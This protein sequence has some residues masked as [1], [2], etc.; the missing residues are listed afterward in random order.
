MQCVMKMSGSA[1][2]RLRGK[3]TDVRSTPITRDW[4]RRHFLDPGSMALS[5]TSLFLHSPR[6]KRGICHRL[7][8]PK[9][10]IC[11]QENRIQNRRKRGPAADWSIGPS[12]IA[13]FE[14]PVFLER[15]ERKKTYH[16]TEAK[17]SLWMVRGNW[18]SFRNWPVPAY[19]S[20]RHAKR[21]G[22][23]PWG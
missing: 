16:T 9:R 21:F 8:E 5:S 11:P 23:L 14:S 7:S 6:P 15:E 12:I 3:R 20:Q 4:G 19:L 13:R 1:P 2:L 22:G 17:N 10:G 18:L